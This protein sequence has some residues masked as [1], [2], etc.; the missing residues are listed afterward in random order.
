MMLFL[1]ASNEVTKDLVLFSL[2]YVFGNWCT[3]REEGG[4]T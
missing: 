1:D 3:M 2:P 4:G